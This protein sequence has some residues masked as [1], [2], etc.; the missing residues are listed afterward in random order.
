MNKAP[1]SSPTKKEAQVLLAVRELGRCDAHQIAEHLGV[2]V[3]V[4]RSHVGR[5]AAFFT[6]LDVARVD[7]LTKGTGR[8]CYHYEYSLSKDGEALL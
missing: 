6:W 2:R 4:V 5:I 3:D 1:R 8:G 7:H